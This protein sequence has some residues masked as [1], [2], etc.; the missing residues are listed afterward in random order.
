MDANRRA[1]ES[2]VEELGPHTKDDQPPLGWLHCLPVIQSCSG[3][4]ACC[5][6]QESP[7]MYLYWL[8]QGTEDNRDDEDYQRVMDLPQQLKTELLAHSDRLVGGGK[9]PRGGACLW[10]DESTGGCRHYDIRPSICREF[11][12]GSDACRSWRQNYGIS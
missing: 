4:G 11:A 12:I 5:R 1:Q 2:I 7:P 8:L 3:C 6:E 9:H 10:F